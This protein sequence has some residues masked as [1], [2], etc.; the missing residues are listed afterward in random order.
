MKLKAILDTLDGLDE[1]FHPLY[2]EKDGKFYF[3]AIDGMATPADVKKLKDEAGA[4]RIELKNLK[5]KYEALDDLGTVEE[6]QAKLD[7]IDELEAASSGKIDETKINE[8]VEA[9]IKGRLT[10]LE[11]ERDRLK[12]ELEEGT[13]A[14]NTYKEKDRKRAIHDHVRQAA[15]KSKIV[16]TAVEDVLLHAERIFDVAEDGTVTTK[17]GVGVTPGVMADVWLTDM[18]QTR[19]HWWPGSQGGGANGGRTTGGNTG[20]NPFSHEGWNLT[21]Q[22]ALV[23]ADR[24]KAEQMAKAAGTTIGGGRPAA[25][26]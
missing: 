18:Q 5:K 13:A 26:K 19:P 22:G 7:R 4:V 20:S 1:H 10:P 12:K 2:T 24:A 23:R 11:R 17:D 6:I 25:K 16:D 3:T 21:A 9:R 14:I 8:M 15:V